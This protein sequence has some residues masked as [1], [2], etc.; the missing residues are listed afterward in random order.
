MSEG[1]LEYLLAEGAIS[2]DEVRALGMFQDAP[3]DLIGGIAFA[4]GLLNAN[5][6]EQIV[7]KQQEKSDS[8]ANLARDLDLLS[9]D[10]VKTLETFH[11]FRTDLHTLEMLILKNI[12]DFPTAAL[13]FGRYF[14]ERA[15]ANGKKSGRSNGEDQSN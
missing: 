11:E 3:S 7:H 9:Q 12:T 15:K 13:L 14:Q 1:F 4:H 6:V 5:Q 8:F 2:K 10:Q